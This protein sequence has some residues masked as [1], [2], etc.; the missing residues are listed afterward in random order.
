MANANVLELETCLAECL[1]YCAA[2]PKQSFVSFYQ[3]RLE[4][5]RERWYDSV[6]LSDA[7]YLDWQREALEDRVAWKRLATELKAT[8]NRLRKVNALGYPDQ[9]VRHWDE[10]ILTAAVREMVDYLQSR[11][12][13]IEIANERIDMLNRLL[14]AA[15]SDD[16]E[17]D[18]ALRSFKRHVLFRADAMGTLG[19]VIGDFRVAMRRELGKKSDDY[20]SIRWPM[21]IAPDEPVL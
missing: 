21:T 20:K 11:A 7:H 10:E 13:V 2:H 1:T 5:A 14:S 17:A 9:T 15:L 12:D 8:Q 16:N 3:P 4:H 19:A 18:T 6:E